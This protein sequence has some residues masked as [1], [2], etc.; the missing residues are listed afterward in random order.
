MKSIEKTATESE[1][2]K[3]RALDGNDERMDQYVTV[4][5]VGTFQLVAR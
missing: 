1:R 4:A 2:G 5:F 3:K